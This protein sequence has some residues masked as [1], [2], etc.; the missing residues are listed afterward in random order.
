MRWRGQRE[1]E[2][3]EDR[4]DEGG[5]FGFPFPGGGVR[6]PSGDS[7]GRG[8]GIGILGLLIIL[9][10]IFFFGLDPRVIM[11]PG[12][13][14]GDG[15]N[16]PD[17]R[18]PRQQPDTTNF[19]FPQTEQGPEIEPPQSASEDD[20]KKFVSVV[21]ANTEDAWQNILGRYGMRYSDP[22][23]VLFTGAVRS[24]CG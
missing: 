22:K 2:N 23:L 16:S 14:G 20:L 18:L 10:L 24:A 1:S 8:G 13:G 7:G 17:F 9:G 21:L 5:G 15:A 4:R 6:F 19:P 3:I 11:G 12:P